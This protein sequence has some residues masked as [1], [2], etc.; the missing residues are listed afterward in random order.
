MQEQRLILPKLLC[1][2]ALTDPIERAGIIT[3]ED[4]AE[5]ENLLTAIISHWKALK[6][7][8][9]AAL[10]EAFLQREGRL[11]QL[12][13]GWQLDVEKKTLDILMGSMPW[14]ISV[15]KYPWMKA[16]LFVNWG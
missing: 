12:E 15:V 4:T 1:G 7:A 9:P 2:M 8:S 6:N 14:G 10:R 3:E 13:N 5:A 16:L 11:T